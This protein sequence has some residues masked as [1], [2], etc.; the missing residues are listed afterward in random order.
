MT[1]VQKRVGSQGGGDHELASLPKNSL[2]YCLIKPNNPNALCPGGSSPRYG[3]IETL[4]PVPQG[5][6][7]QGHRAAMRLTVRVNTSALHK[8]LF[9]N[10]KTRTSGDSPNGQ[11]WR[12]GWVNCGET[13]TIEPHRAMKNGGIETTHNNLHKSQKRDGAEREVSEDYNQNK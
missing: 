12:N 11:R 6:H 13:P 8:N 10:I 4:S 1:P 7:A 3:C 5:T 9:L 2:L